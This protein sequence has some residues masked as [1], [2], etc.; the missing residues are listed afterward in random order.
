M[1]YDPTRQVPPPGYAPQPGY[2]RGY[3]PSQ[4]PYP[5]QAYPGSAPQPGYAPGYVPPQPVAPTPVYGSSPYPQYGA[6]SGAAPGGGFDFNRFWQ[7]L[8]LNGKAA[9]LVGLLTLIVFFFPWYASADPN[10]TVTD[11]YTGSTGPYSGTGPSSVSVTVSNTATYSGFNAA[12]G[13]EKLPQYN[14]LVS[15]SNDTGVF[16]SDGST[17]PTVALSVYLWLVPLVGLILLIAAWLLSKSRLTSRQTTIALIASSVLLA[18]LEL[19]FLVTMN[20]LQ[21]DQERTLNSGNSNVTV[22]L[23]ST[24][25]GVAWGFWLALI[26]ALAGLVAGLYVLSQERKGLT[27]AVAVAQPYGGQYSSAPPVYPGA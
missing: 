21:N 15:E 16:R 27:P 18:L 14:K 23:N 13:I 1:S 17:P 22:Q 10:G 7:S 24:L 20:S 2:T 19:S 3:P 25:Y 26:A 6:P 5:P 12:N 8:G 11:T 4:Q 9:L